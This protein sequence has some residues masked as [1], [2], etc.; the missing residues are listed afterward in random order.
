MDVMLEGGS[1]QGTIG[2]I[3]SKSTAHRALICAAL[4]DGPTKIRLPARNEDIDATISCLRALGAQVTS[5]AARVVVDPISVLPKSANLNCGESGSTLRF[6]LPVTAA[7]LGE[8]WFS[9]QGNLPNR[10][11]VELNTVLEN[12]GIR[13]SGSRLPFQISGNLR[14]GIYEIEGNISSQYISGLLFALPLLN[15]DSRIVLKSALCSE[16]YVRLTIDILQKFGIQTKTCDD[17]YLVHGKQVYSSPGQMN[18]EGDWSASAFLLTAGALGG[19]VTVTDLNPYSLQGDR[20]V[21]EILQQFGA[22]LNVSENAVRVQ[23][24]RLRACAVDVSP[25]PDLLPPLAVL[26]CGAEG[27]TVL[28]NASHLRYKESDRLKSTAEMINALG[29]KASA[30]PDRLEIEGARLSGGTVSSFGDHRIVMA[31]AVAAGI[32]D[33][34]TTILDADAVSKSYPGFFRDFSMLGGK[35]IF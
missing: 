19:D 35:I 6:L 16:P 21:V 24:A 25:I 15:D 34:K 23:K 32:C 20:A 7:L 30:F 10:P 14:A 29:G 31:A 2:S 26:A 9:G 33:G 11:I 17:G 22:A 3:P 5:E 8:A 18:I 12:H 4:A 1:L 27:K 28:Y 13:F